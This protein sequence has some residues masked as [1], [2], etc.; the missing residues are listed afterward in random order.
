MCQGFHYGNYVLI[1]RLLWSKL[2][3]YG[4]KIREIENKFG[5]KIKNHEKEIRVSG[6]KESVTP[7]LAAVQGVI[8]GIMLLD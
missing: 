2:V 7:A 3:P 5:C 4:A 6:P 8:T 1:F